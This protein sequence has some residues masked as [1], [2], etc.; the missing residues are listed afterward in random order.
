MRARGGAK[1]YLVLLN[2]SS[3]T[4]DYPGTVVISNT[5]IAEYNGRLV[6]WEAVVLRADHA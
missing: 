2:F 4:A 1:R 5:G 3:E 6:P